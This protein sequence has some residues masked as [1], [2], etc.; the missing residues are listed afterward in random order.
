M[1]V[2]FNRRE[3][4]LRA[5][6]AIQAQSRRP[7]TVIVI[8]NA[9]ADGTAAALRDRFPDVD[10]VVLSRNVGGAGGFA[11]G[12]ARALAGGAE[13]VWLMDDDSV[14]ERDALA[15]LLAARDG[16]PGA[17]PALLASRVVWTDGRDHPMNTPR[18]RPL[19]NR[20][21]LDA[22]AVVG[23]TPI[24][25]ASFVSVLV[26]ADAVRVAGLPTADFFLWNDDFEFTARLLRHRDGLLC[27]ASVVVHHTR[28]F[29]ASDVDPGER[30]YYEVR[31][32][33]W[34]LRRADV[35]GPVDRALYGAA[36]L[37]RWVRTYARSTQRPVLRRALLRGLRDGTRTRPRPTSLVLAD[38]EASAVHDATG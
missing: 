33:V 11:Y 24:R 31:N 18:T 35:L 37:R 19:A 29:G 27:P 12:L 25:S 14:A 22:A 38:I 2:T 30:F 3:L 23:C 4:V 20:C 17:P 10:L 36:T 13:L 7:D 15:G 5:V 34:T 6:E 16:Y 21:R 32:K 1:V 28:A 8:D 26:D 9:S